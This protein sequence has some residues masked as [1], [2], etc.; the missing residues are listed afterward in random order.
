MRES[1]AELAGLI[2]RYA[3]ADGIHETPIPRLHL[4]R[5]SRTTEPIYALHEP[6]LCLIAQGRKQAMLGSQVY[7]YDRAQYLRVSVDVPVVGQVI[8]ASPQSPY[9]SL[10]FD[11][12]PEMLSALL[13]EVEGATAGDGS[14]GPALSPSTV[15]P[16]LP[17]SC[18]CWRSRRISP[19]LRLW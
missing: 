1:L 8:E 19:L 9:L 18:V 10:R 3:G 12:D 2:D 5:S 6:A 17:A 4:F 16:E 13:L 14:P 11:L 15:T 7:V